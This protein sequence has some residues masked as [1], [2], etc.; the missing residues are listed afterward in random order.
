MSDPSSPPS[1]P[2]VALSG[3]SRAENLAR[4]RRLL[5]LQPSPRRRLR[6]PP[7]SPGALLMK[8]AAGPLLLPCISRGGPR[9]PGRRPRRDWRHR[10]LGAWWRRCGPVP[11]SR[12]DGEVA[13]G[14]EPGRGGGGFGSAASDLAAYHPLRRIRKSSPQ[15]WPAP[16][17][18]PVLRRVGV[19]TGRLPGEIPS[20]PAGCDGGDARGRRAPSWRRW[21][22]IPSPPPPPCTPG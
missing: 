17:W 20:R 5:P 22:G 15:I 6:Q 11:L 21:S 3:D 13:G 9:N 14:C 2:R 7:A 8:V 1:L 10:I 18:T 19:G 12:V 4:R 16:S